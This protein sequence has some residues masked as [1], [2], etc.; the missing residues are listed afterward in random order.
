MPVQCKKAINQVPSS[1]MSSHITS[2]LQTVPIIAL[3]AYP[4]QGFMAFEVSCGKHVKD[5][6]ITV[7][8]SFV[9][10]FM[11]LPQH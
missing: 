3:T 1:F 9:G 7:C 5:K 4:K 8:S 11:L 2:E 10:L 6:A